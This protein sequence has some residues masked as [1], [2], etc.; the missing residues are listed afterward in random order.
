MKYNEHR[1][2]GG[3]I[4]EYL[5]GHEDVSHGLFSTGD[6]SL[7]FMCPLLSEIAEK[8]PACTDT[9][10]RYEACLNFHGKVW[11]APFD[12][13]I[14]QGVDV[15]FCPAAED[16]GFLEIKIRLVREAGEA[17][18]WRRINKGF[19]NELRKQLLVWRSLDEIA[20][21][22]YER[23]LDVTLKEKGVATER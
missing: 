21:D 11:L 2:I 14:M 8:K 6:L 22:H 17:N 7:V 20:Q 18:A 12:F 9:V 13:G 5:R 3:F 19:L 16:P 1:G 23:A 10:C 15:Q 4:F